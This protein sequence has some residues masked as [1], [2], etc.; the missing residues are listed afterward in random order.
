MIVTIP[1]D[2]QHRRDDPQDRVGRAFLA[3]V[4]RQQRQP[5]LNMFLLGVRGIRNRSNA[6]RRLSTPSRKPNPCLDVPG[7]WRGGSWLL[8]QGRRLWEAFIGQ[9]AVKGGVEMD[10]LK[11]LKRDHGVVKKLLANL[12]DT[13]ER[14]VK[15]RPDRAREPEAGA[16]GARED[17]GGDLSYPALKEHPK[18]KDIALEA[19]EEHHVVDMVMG[20]IET[21]APS[22]ETWMAKF[23]V[24]KENLEHH[25]EEEE[26]GG[27]RLAGSAGLRRRGTQGARSA[28]AGSKGRVERVGRRTAKGS[29]LGPGMRSQP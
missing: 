22:D 9:Y 24:M 8:F 28:D 13:T 5:C 4:L 18:T 15:T 1:I 6:E 26:G 7:K 21:T 2:H 12:E 25:I 10:A 16:Q 27:C 20:E 19:Y 11:L 3:A 23:M 14:A 17:R 29:D